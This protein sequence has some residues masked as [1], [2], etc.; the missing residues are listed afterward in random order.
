MNASISGIDLPIV[1]VYVVSLL[2]YGLYRARKVKT[3]EDFLVAGR[4][5][6]V[7][8]LTSTLVMAELNSATLMAFAGVG[9]SAGLWAMLLP[10][11]VF[12]GPFLVYAVTVAKKWKRLDAVS[13]N[14]LFSQR[15]GDTTSLVTTIVLILV[16]SW[17]CSVYLKA[18]ALVFEVAFGI[19]LTQTILI[20]CSVVLCITLAGGLLSV[21]WTDVVSFMVTIVVIPAMF[22]IAW[23][24]A[25]GMEGLSQV[26]PPHYLGINPV[27]NWADPVLSTQFMVAFFFLILLIYFSAPHI[28]QRMFAGK[29]EKTVFWAV[30]LNAVIT[31]CLYALVMGAAA[32]AKTAWP[33]L[34][35]ENMSLSF[36]HVIVDWLPAGLRG[37]TLGIIFAICQTT[38]CAI[39]NTDAAMIENDV[40]SRFINPNPTDRERLLVSRVVTVLLGA[41]T[42]ILALTVIKYLMTSLLITNILLAMLFFPC[43]AGFYVWHINQKGALASMVVCLA[44]GA[45]TMVMNWGTDGLD[46]NAW[47]PLYV[48]AVVPLT[49]ATG[50]VTSLLTKTSATETAMRIAFYERVGPPL[51]G[52]KHYLAAKA[53]VGFSDL[54]PSNE[55]MV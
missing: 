54:P 51:I 3:S 37:V 22:V 35:G 19:G 32:L 9:Y 24:K 27:Q 7:I 45:V 47:M 5:V 6:G 14:T 15:Y 30:C 4:S 8:G 17:L 55:S 31:G 52:R 42:I 39:W 33:D 11:F 21:I 34:T 25:G 46:F 40:Y 50:I 18:A 13:V 43:V 26:Y 28:A 1:V 38:M 23:Q 44:T 16:Y 2:A 12:S 36:A 53:S 41:L 49:F 29:S 48:C 10:F 20:M